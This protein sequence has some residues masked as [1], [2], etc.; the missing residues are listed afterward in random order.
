MTAAD[1]IARWKNSGGAELANSQSFL[2][3][4]CQ[5]LDVPQPEPTLPDES[6]NVYTFEKAVEFNNGD[7][8]TSSGRV[9]LYRKKCFVL[10]SKQGVERREKEKAEALASVTKAKKLRAGTAQRGTPA[11]EQAMTK[12]RTQAKLYAEALP[13]EWPPFLIVADIGYCFDIYADF[14]QSGK[15]YN[16]FPDPQSYRIWLKDLEQEETRQFL[17]AIWLDPLPSLRNSNH[18]RPA[19]DQRRQPSGRNSTGC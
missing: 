11:W 15:N 4:L 18:N 8:T 5:L 14:T 6:K 16:Q 9:D 3:E 1:F 2:K 10:E 17:R 19:V 7:G 13:D 12:A